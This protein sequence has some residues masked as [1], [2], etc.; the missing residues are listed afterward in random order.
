M[1]KYIYRSGWMVS[2]SRHEYSLLSTRKSWPFCQPLSW[3]SAACIPQI[4]AWAAGSFSDLTPQQRGWGRGWERMQRIVWG[5][6][7]MKKCE[8]DRGKGKEK[9]L[10]E[11]RWCRR[12][13][14]E[15]P[16][17]HWVTQWYFISEACFSLEPYLL[18]NMVSESKIETPENWG[19][20]KGHQ[21]EPH[22]LPLVW[23]HR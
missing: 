5:G 9:L 10:R 20:L 16:L 13:E 19:V 17:T 3:S 1:V 6:D 7:R 21:H 11:S 15:E 18:W 22:V 12:E 23:Y 14:S 8:K 4:I 2:D